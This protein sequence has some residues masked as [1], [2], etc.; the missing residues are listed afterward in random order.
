MWNA[1]KNVIQSATLVRLD[2]INRF[3]SSAINPPLIYIKA[4]KNGIH[5][6]MNSSGC[7]FRNSIISRPYFTSSISSMCKR[8]EHTNL[9]K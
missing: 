7:V 8:R 6:E 3:M 9:V 4:I 1:T 5:V 2:N